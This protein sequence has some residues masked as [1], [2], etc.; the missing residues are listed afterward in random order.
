[1]W[2][3]SLPGFVIPASVVCAG[4]AGP[5]LLGQDQAGVTVE[6]LPP[7]QPG[8]RVR[9]KV[10]GPSSIEWVTF[11]Y[12]PAGRD[13][14]ESVML[15]RD[16]GSAFSIELEP[17]AIPAGK[18]DYYLAMKDNGDIDYLPESAPSGFQGF[19]MPAGSGSARAAAQGGPEQGAGPEARYSW[20]FHVSGTVEQLLHHQN[21]VPGERQLSASGQMELGFVRETAEDRLSFD[22][23]M[24][25]TNQPYG[26]QGR[27]YLA[28]LQADYA[29][30]NNR[31][32]AGDLVVQESEFTVSGA[33]R[34]GMDYTYDDQRLYVHAFAVNTQQLP[35]L[36]GAA[37]PHADTRL[38]GGALGYQF[39]DGHWNWKLVYLDGKDDL[40]QAV[41]G[42]SVTGNKVRE[43]TTVALVQEAILFQNRLNLSTEY[44]R[45]RV[46]QDV[47]DS[48]APATDQAW[49][50][51]GLY[52]EGIF[53]GRLSYRRL[54]KDF[55]T[56]GQTGF[57]GDRVSVDGSA[58]IALRDWTFNFTALDETNNPGGSALDP[59]ARNQSQ[60]LDGR[61]SFNPAATA[62][63]G[64][65]RG[66]QESGA[67][68]NPQIPFSNSDRKGGM[69]GLDLNLGPRVTL[70]STCQVDRLESSD[71]TLGRSETE[72]LGGTFTLSPRLRLS[73]NLTWSRIRSEPSAEVTRVFSAF[74]NADMTFIP[75][76]LTFTMTAGYSRTTLPAGIGLRTTTGDAVL[77]MPLGRY[78]HK[79]TCTLGLRG[80][81]TRQDNEGQLVQ[82]DNSLAL[83]LNFSL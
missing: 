65:S 7:A 70:T 36:A 3:S 14:F 38:Y 34:R 21:E 10:A 26:N 58:S 80:R 8:D 68:A 33:G 42:G 35:G 37:W 78:L 29:R 52:T 16:G 23:R 45:S 51:T 18:V 28:G 77:L 48:Q 61:W 44:A 25:Y 73:P 66:H 81:Y 13:D 46:D 19:T 22:A 40:S 11:F 62:R 60:T 47:S 71:G 55:D 50:V 41:N 30:K 6:V 69:V 57:V 15:K 74:L 27:T 54:G 72:L 31:V 5:P 76:A 1:M 39:L 79:G 49:R 2:K 4:L 20:P 75:E 43:G 59:K 56:L 64:V 32:R 67:Q 17:D 9:I 63:F 12:R 24:G 53:T 83:T 82:T